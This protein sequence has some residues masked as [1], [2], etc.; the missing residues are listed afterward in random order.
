MLLW[1]LFF[2]VVV[3][4]RLVFIVFAGR[5]PMLLFSLGGVGFHLLDDPHPLLLGGERQLLLDSWPLLLGG[6]RPLL[7]GSELLVLLVRGG[8]LIP[9]AMYL[10]ICTHS[11]ASS[12]S[13]TGEG[14][15]M[16]RGE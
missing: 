16:K 7:I 14:G 4:G 6:G 12:D 13:F 5:G 10:S 2:V 11:S 8:V 15:L 9:F 1:L 3:D